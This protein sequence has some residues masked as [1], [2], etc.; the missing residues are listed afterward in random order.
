MD[1]TVNQI[2][3]NV[4]KD[5]HNDDLINTNASRMIN[6]QWEYF[7]GEKWTALS[8]SDDTDSFHQSG[9]VDFVIP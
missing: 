5:F 1:E 7:N 6:L 4:F 9:F 3:K 2:E 8:V